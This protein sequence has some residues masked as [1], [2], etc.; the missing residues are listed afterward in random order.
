[1]VDGPPKVVPLSPYFD[2]DLIQMPLP[3]WA[4]SHRFRAPFPDLMSEI[5][6]EPVHPKPNTFMA[7]V[8]TALVQ[9]VFDIAQR[10][11]ESDIHHHAKLDDLRRGFEVAERVL[12]HFLRLDA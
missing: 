2:E 6:P 8:D 12:G 4:S 11:R 9:E 3:L 1:V 7:D 5:R 10:Q